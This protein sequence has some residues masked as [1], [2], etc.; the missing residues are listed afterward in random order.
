MPKHPLVVMALGVTLAAAAPR[1][2]AQEAARTGPILVVPFDNA[3]REARYHWLAEASAV[4]LT[5]HLE[6]LGAAAITRDDRRDAFDRLQLPSTASLTQATLI[7]LGELVG[8]VYLV[9]GTYS[10]SGERLSVRGQTIRLDSGQRVADAVEEAPLGEMLPLFQRLARRIAPPGEGSRTGLL[11]DIGPLPAFEAYIKGV[12]AE[13]PGARERFLQTALALAPAYEDARVALWRTHTEQGEHARAL[14][15]IERV[16]ASSPAS[17]RARF[18]AALSRV[19]L[20]QYDEAFEALT[21]LLAE[22]PSAALHNNL[23]VIQLRRGATPQTG[24]PTYHFT[25]AVEAAPDDPDFHFNLGYAYWQERDPQAAIYWLKET[26]RR[27]PGDG[28]A[29][30]VL[31]ASLQAAGATAEASR[32]KELASQLSS[33]FA[34]W[35]RRASASADPVPRGLERLRMDLDAPRLSLLQRVVAPVEQKDQRDLAAFYLERAR[36][37]ADQA[38]DVEAL[39]ELRRSIY[40][41]PYQAE[42]HLLAGRIH[43][44]AGR[45]TEAARDL[46]ISLWC[47]ETAAAHVALGQV[48]LEQKDLL[49]AQI[50]ANR[51]LAMD[52]GNPE[53]RALLEKAGGKK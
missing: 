26:V 20:K 29:H 31:S 18:L 42:A 25:K 23:G 51:A 52:V 19:A 22:S 41:S 35:E 2:H 53:A 43:A 46:R 10:V 37:L 6:A 50:E 9:S 28:E 32:E 48:L 30:Y 44:R 39:A 8:A 7:R 34:E 4:L 24:R 13:S 14:A 3:G 45:L 36:R 21:A 38:R 40:I 15:A 12:V 49:G 27:N 17:R 47:Q 5:R 33:T 16:A 11:P 1:A